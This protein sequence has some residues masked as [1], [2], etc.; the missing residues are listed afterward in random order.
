MQSMT[1]GSAV[2][3]T[4]GSRHARTAVRDGIAQPPTRCGTSSRLDHVAAM[5]CL[6]AGRVAVMGLPMARGLVVAVDQG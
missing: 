2:G 3:F 4:P 1:E 5:G 6:A